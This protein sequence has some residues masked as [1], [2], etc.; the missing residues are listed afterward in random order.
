[1]K[2][3]KGVGHMR[4]VF[5]L[6]ERNGAVRSLHVP[7]SVPITSIRSCGTPRPEAA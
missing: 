3:S 7:T 4:P 2:V 6:V 5:S 1:M